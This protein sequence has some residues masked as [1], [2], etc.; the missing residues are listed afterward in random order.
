MCERLYELDP[1]L[2]PKAEPIKRPVSPD[3]SPDKSSPVR[4]VTQSK[5]EEPAKISPEPDNRKKRRIMT[6]PTRT[7]AE[8]QL[9]IESEAVIECVF[10]KA[11]AK[12]ISSIDKAP[13]DTVFLGRCSLLKSVQSVACDL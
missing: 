7:Q 11:D 10:D 2:R 1:S 12:D 4:Q 6:V 5:E 9:S 13:N 8:A 3:K